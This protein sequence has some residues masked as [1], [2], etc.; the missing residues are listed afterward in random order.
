MA[1]FLPLLFTLCGAGDAAPVLSLCTYQ[2]CLPLLPGR[3][4]LSFGVVG[5]RLLSLS[6][7][8]C[9]LRASCFLVCGLFPLRTIYCNGA[10][11]NSLLSRTSALKCRQHERAVLKAR[12]PPCLLRCGPSIDRAIAAPQ[13]P[14]LLFALL[15]LVVS[16]DN[17]NSLPSLYRTPYS[18]IGYHRLLFRTLH[19][20]SDTPIRCVGVLLRCVASASRILG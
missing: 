6:L 14:V 17:A 9:C 3:F 8:D 15:Q 7:A 2:T 11:G 13:S 4:I 16:C 19:D 20:L 5:R 18:D 12:A 10:K 1:V